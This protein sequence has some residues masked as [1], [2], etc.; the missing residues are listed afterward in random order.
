[1]QNLW[2]KRKTEKK[3]K[4]EKKNTRWTPGIP[5][6]PASESAHGPARNNPETVCPLSLTQ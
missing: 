4:K 6:G 2:K 3:K 1:M 5:F